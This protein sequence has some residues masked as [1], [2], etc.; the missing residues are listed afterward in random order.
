MRIIKTALVALGFHSIL[1]YA[2][3]L[4][5]SIFSPV[6]FSSSSTAGIEVFD[7]MSR[8]DL[9]T[10]DNG[11]P[12]W[13]RGTGDF[14][15][16]YFSRGFSDNRQ[17]LLLLR[18]SSVPDKS[19]DA[20]KESPYKIQKSVQRKWCETK[21]IVAYKWITLPKGRIIDSFDCHV[22]N[23]MPLPRRQLVVG[24]VDSGRKSGFYKARK[25]WRISAWPSWKGGGISEFDHSSVYCTVLPGIDDIPK[26]AMFAEHFPSYHFPHCAPDFFPGF[27]DS[28]KFGFVLK[29]YRS[30]FDFT[31]Q[32]TRL[33]DIV[34]AG[35]LG[36]VKIYRGGLGG[37]LGDCVCYI[38][39]KDDTTVIFSVP[40][41]YPNDGLRRIWVGRS[42]YVDIRHCTRTDLVNRETGKV[43]ALALGVRL[44]DVKNVLGEPGLSKDSFPGLS[45]DSFIGYTY[46][47]AVLDGNG[48]HFIKTGIYLEIVAKDGRV[49]WFSTGGHQRMQSHPWATISSD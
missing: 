36:K 18:K 37:N 6:A 8:C 16:E 28:E 19:F 22:T 46:S 23:D 45:G 7:G 10:E 40:S 14:S 29:N 35:K 11:Y 38:S 2:N 5:A 48:E 9:A 17:L 26:N 31:L 33:S 13:I 12:V 25:S 4:S 34:R 15:L 41:W 32:E 3:S 44:E 1:I 43:G 30:L 24:L 21:K 49:E 39:N 20:A 27:T 47:G 42:L